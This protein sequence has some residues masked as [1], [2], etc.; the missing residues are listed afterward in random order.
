ML[1]D[2]IAAGHPEK[3][4][5]M[6]GLIRGY[7]SRQ[8]AEDAQRWATNWI[9][10]SPEDWQPWFLRALARTQLSRNLLSTPFEQAKQDYHKV[11]ELKPNHA[12]ARL[13]LANAYTMTGQFQEALPHF[14]I[15]CER[16]PDERGTVELARCHRALGHIEEARNVLDTWLADHAGG[17]DV[18]L[19]R[20]QVA[21]DLN[22][23]SEALDWFRKAEKLAPANDK[24]H[25]QLAQVLRALG[26]A[27]EGDE[28]EQKW[29]THR[30]LTQ[31]LGELQ[32]LAA[33]EPRNVAVRHEAGAIALRLGQEDAGL[34]W[35]AGALQIDPKHRPTHEALAEHF[36][37]KGQTQAAE[38]HRRLAQQP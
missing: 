20:G 27:A 23:S 11:L 34:R 16:Q 25:F 31:R 22:Q 18:F 10:Q 33:K 15:Y 5:L 6:E 30:Q 32:Q 17:A 7:L 24:I 36:A 8:R 38:H 28:Y 14:Q 1:R 12:V 21:M 3:R 26:R 4:L 2:K 37:R 13:L 9:E 29:T 19:V 35:L